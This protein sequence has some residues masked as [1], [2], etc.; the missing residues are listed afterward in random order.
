MG[1]RLLLMRHAKSSWKE[2]GKTDFER[3]LNKRGRRVAPQMGRYLAEHGLQPQKVISS[4]AKRAHETCDLLQTEFQGLTDDDIQFVRFLYLAPAHEYLD[5]L[6]RY[7]EPEVETLLIL[8]HNPGLEQAVYELG[9]L[10]ESMP[11][12]AVADIEF[13]ADDWMEVRRPFQARLRQV[14]RPK[15]IGID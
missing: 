9:G 1:K 15:E 4:S 10:F 13:E 3:S 11:T 2:E 6:E 8:G 12:A 5:L 7:Y 14:L